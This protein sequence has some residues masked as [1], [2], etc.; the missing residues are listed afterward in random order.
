MESPV[1]N[2]YITGHKDLSY[3]TY[4]QVMCEVEN[5][6]YKDLDY[7]QLEIPGHDETIYV[8]TEYIDDPDVYMALECMYD[9]IDDQDG[10]HN[11]INNEVGT[12]A[13][14][15]GYIKVGAFTYY[16]PAYV[17]QIYHLQIEE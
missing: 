7:T 5:V 13:T 4:E 9:H 1:I 17:L 6:C 16:G 8:R 10:I 14:E 2:V 12:Y 3:N 15:D 11:C